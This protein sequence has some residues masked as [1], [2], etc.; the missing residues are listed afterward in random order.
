MGQT[1]KHLIVLMLENRSFDHM[2]GFMAGPGYPVDGLT[3][4]ESCPVSAHDPTPVRVASDASAGLPFD[5]GHQ[6]ADTNCQIYFNH[7]GPPV[8]PGQQAN[9]G[10]VASYAEQKHVTPETAPRIMSCF[11][12]ADLP[13]LS[14]LAREFAVCDRWFS[15]VPGP[16]WPNRLFVH[17][18]TSKGRVANE[19]SVNYDMPTIFESL[20]AAGL[21]W[22]VYS[23]DFPLTQM[24]GRLTLPEFDRNWDSIGGFKRDCRHG[25]LPHY[26][27]IEPKYTHLFGPGN[28][29]HPPEDIDRGDQLI[30]DV[31]HSVRTSPSWND[32]MLV[33][34]YD[35][36]GGTYDHVMPPENAVAPDQHTKQFSFTRLGIRVP[37]VLVSPW[38]ARETIVHREFDHSSVAATVKTIF[39]L[40]GFLTRRDAA[41]NT[42]E[43]VASLA[44]PRTDAPTRFTTD[45]D[46]TLTEW[47]D[48]VTSAHRARMLMATGAP[49]AAP[50]SD[51]QLALVTLARERA[52][53]GLDAQ[54][55]A[56]DV[57]RP[58]LTEHD[59]AIYLREAA[60]RIRQRHAGRNTTGDR[61]VRSRRVASAAD[62]NP[63]V[64][65]H[66]AQDD[67]GFWLLSVERGDG[68]MTV[69]QWQ[70][71]A[72]DPLIES[73][74]HLV[75]DGRYPGAVVLFDPPRERGTRSMMRMDSSYSKPAPRRAGRR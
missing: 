30:D 67:E 54:T 47:G 29:Q 72:A 23:H 21:S 25:T 70:S 53:E 34:T 11:R 14:G 13:A 43:G 59:A 42:F 32:T 66:I 75:R 28:S 46:R 40:P 56:L 60:A 3:G 18:A 73:A 37:T 44:A 57:M 68:T 69:L 20:S 15:S 26:C 19:P 48:E 39:G 7:A 71:V 9:T 64:A 8:A 61:D 55:V 6:F 45:D 62:D 58:M 35:E 74:Y 33:V 38:I 50:M 16:T 5:A 24:F 63:G 49:S 36:H 17:A 12:P 22:K 41:A 52:N 10:F 1:I 65:L 31:Y 4:D 51:L 27:F 2:L